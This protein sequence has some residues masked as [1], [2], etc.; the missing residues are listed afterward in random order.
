MPSVTARI[1]EITKEQ[2]RGGY[3]P[4]KDFEKIELTDGETLSDIQL[5]N[6]HTSIVGLAVDY[7]TRFMNGADKAEAFFISLQGARVIGEHKTAEKLLDSIVGLDDISIVSVCKL[8]GFDVVIRAGK[9]YKPV[10][11]I[12]PNRETIDNIRIMVERSLNFIKMYGP[13][14]KDGFTFEGAYTD[15]VSSGDGDF[16]TKD[17]LWDFKVTI[18]NP[19]KDHTLQLLMYYLMGKKTTANYFDTITKIGIY[20]PRKNIVYSKSVDEIDDSVIHIVE[21]DVIGYGNEELNNEYRERENELLNKARARANQP[22]RQSRRR[23][24]RRKQSNIYI[25]VCLFILVFLLITFMMNYR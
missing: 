1:K 3:V 12:N 20:N 7:L 16:L 5:E 21:H 25:A 23:T 15:V 19:S 6:V 17:T 22:Q 18:A 4:I 9:G 2:P 14:V 13:I 24:R 11:E 8:S 10:S